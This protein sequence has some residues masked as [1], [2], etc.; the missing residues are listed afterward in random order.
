MIQEFTQEIKNRVYDMLRE[1]H[2]VIPGEIIDFNPDKVE[3]TVLPFGKYKKTDGSMLD[4]P[5]IFEVPV[6]FPQSFG[7]TATVVYP[8]KPKDYCLLFIAEQTLDIW[9]T[10]AAS[11]TDLRF[12]LTNA[13]ALVGLFA[14]P[15]PLVRRAHDN[16][17][18]IVQREN[19]YAEILDKRIEIYTDGDVNIT[20]AE[21]ASTQA[22]T[23]NETAQELIALK[24]PVITVGDY[25]SV[26][27]TLIRQKL[28]RTMI[29]EVEQ[30]DLT[31]TITPQGN[32]T[33]DSAA[34]ITVTSQGDISLTSDTNVNITAPTINST[35]F[36]NHDGDVYISGDIEVVGNA[37]IGGDTTIAGNT[38][39]GGDTTIAGT[40]DIGGNTTIA[41]NTEIGGDLDVLGEITTPKITA[42]EVDISGN[43][44][45]AHVHGG[46]LPGGAATG[47]P[48]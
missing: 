26:T 6:F 27:P 22:T 25:L 44:F 14:Q 45:A 5:K 3:A 29:L 47:P 34:D 13:I 12:D 1:V 18:I 9:R 36:L 23:I 33:I 21:N 31:I 39:I 7:Q 24:A 10:S 32:I 40:T 41:G 46:V 28:R 42:D 48:Q 43:S 4:F 35:A 15:N 11:N 2:T 37:D 8:V 20:A 16:E 19:S 30:G 38:D 17:S